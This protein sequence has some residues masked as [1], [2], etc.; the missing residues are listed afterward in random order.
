[1]RTNERKVAETILQEKDKKITVAGVE[2]TFGKPTVATM[3]MISALVSELP[4]V[5]PKAT[6]GNIVREVLRTAKDSEKIGEIAAVLILGAKRVLEHRMVSRIQPKRRPWSIFLPSDMETIQTE[7]KDALAKD[8]LEEMT[9]DEL[10]GLIIGR[11]SDLHVGSF[12]GLTTS[13]TTANILKATKSGVEG[14]T[15]VSGQ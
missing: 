4:S 2:Y 3:I 10:Q 7:E 5:D 13:L 14:K 11:I 12:F 8:L 1:M 9:I 15:T 6:G